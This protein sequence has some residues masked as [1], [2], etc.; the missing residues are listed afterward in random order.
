[1][2]EPLGPAS[3][4][5]SLAI[6]LI[7]SPLSD[8]AR[9]GFPTKPHIPR[10]KN[11]A[12]AVGMRRPNTVHGR[13]EEHAK[14]LGTPTEEMVRQR[15]AEI[16]MTNGRSEDQFTQADLDQAQRELEDGQNTPVADSSEEQQEFVPR[17]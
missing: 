1:M 5:P 8:T 7:S 9:Y 12:Y 4:L 6:F 15:A 3:S 14:G 13:I 2:T 17:E 11:G 16:A 10:H